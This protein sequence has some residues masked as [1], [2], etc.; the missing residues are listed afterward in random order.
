MTSEAEDYI[1][2]RLSR[3]DESLEEARLLLQN[4]HLNGAVNRLYY[5][6]FYS[7]SAL[8]YTEERFSAKHSGVRALFDQ[9]W[10]NTGRVPAEM[11][12]V[13]RRLF[14]RRQKSDYADLV[15]FEKPQVVEWLREAEQFVECVAASTRRNISQS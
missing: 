13:Y 11:G 14:E 9:H 4:G 5:G 6:C 7:V 15:S 1:R 8:L 3:A 10:V 2:Y 12:R